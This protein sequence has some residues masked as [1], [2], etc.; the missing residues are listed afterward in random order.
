MYLNRNKP[1]ISSIQDGRHL[2][3]LSTEFPTP[4]KELLTRR[5]HYI[6]VKEASSHEV[7]DFIVGEDKACVPT[8]FRF[9]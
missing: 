7:G 6:G 2:L 1:L 8:V 5:P 4:C 3:N 9:A